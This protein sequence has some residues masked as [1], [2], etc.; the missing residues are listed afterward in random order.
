MAFGQIGD[1]AKKPYGGFF[2]TNIKV[3]ISCNETSFT[4]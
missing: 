4:P 3:V 2:V 1:G